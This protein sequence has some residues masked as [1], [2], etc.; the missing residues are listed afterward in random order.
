MELRHLRYF[1]MA[2][3]E[4]SFHRASLRLNV[5]Q[6][7]LSRQIR[8]L[9]EE[10]DVPLF[11]R[12]AQGVKL[13][14][15]G[16][17][18]LTEVKRLLTQ[19]ELARTRTKRAAMGQFGLLR[20][21]FTMLAA[22]FRFAMAAF[23]DAR[24][25][26]PDV[27]FRLSLIN[28]DHQME[29]LMNGEIDVGLLYR[30]EPHPP[31]TVYRDLRIESYKLIVPS[32]HP[33][34][35]RSRVKLAD[36]RDEN[37]A[38]VSP[39]LRPATYSEMMGACVRSGLTPRIVLEVDNEAILIN[40]V[41]EGIVIGFVNSSLSERRPTPGVTFVTIEDLDVPLHLAAM[42]QRDRETTAITH[43]VDLLVEHMEA[44]QDIHEIRKS[45]RAR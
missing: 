17:V 12:S 20:I 27:D 24:R 42:W 9:E 28:S 37:M 14:P 29:A 19:I 35:T 18:F 5:A 30:R 3:A 22:E 34:T 44:D 43:F 6:P 25:S 2:A 15:A 11:V 33:L 4:G 38:F 36:L 40:L 16:E 10:L 13:S 41:A 8:D 32:G 23:G 21:G 31:G 39:T 45:W 7:A 26:M 1:A